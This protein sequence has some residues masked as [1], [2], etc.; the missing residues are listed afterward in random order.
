MTCVLTTEIVWL[1]HISLSTINAV[2]GAELIRKVG[3]EAVEAACVIELP[4]LEGRSKLGGLPLF[5]LV[6][7]AGI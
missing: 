5:V 6:Q 3:A 1:E 4:E 2:A 7:K